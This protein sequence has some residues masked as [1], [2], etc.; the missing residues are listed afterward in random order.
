MM[1][2]ERINRGQRYD[3]YLREARRMHPKE[4]PKH[5]THHSRIESEKTVSTSRPI[6]LPD[7]D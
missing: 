6:I 2:K 1:D 3:Q 7:E 4:Y 5:V